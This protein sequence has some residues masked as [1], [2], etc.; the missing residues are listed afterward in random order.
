[1]KVKLIKN[2]VNSDK[3]FIMMNSDTSK[4]L[5]IGQNYYV[6]AISIESEGVYF[7]LFDDFYLFPVPYQMFE[8]V[9]SDIPVQWKITNQ[10]GTIFLCHDLFNEPYFYDKFSDHDISLVEKF[11]SLASEMYPQLKYAKW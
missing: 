8:I 11:K 7:Y 2:K 1:M 6:F 9:E 4:L 5:K 10:D 3:D